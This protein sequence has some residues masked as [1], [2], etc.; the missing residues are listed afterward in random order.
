MVE[1]GGWPRS[2]AANPDPRFGMTAGDLGG[3]PHGDACSSGRCSHSRRGAPKA[4]TITIEDR[5]A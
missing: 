4:P 1:I 2:W 5:T 3:N